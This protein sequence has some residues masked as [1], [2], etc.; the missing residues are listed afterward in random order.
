M[1]KKRV[2]D[3][4]KTALVLAGGG[5]TGV[6]YEMGAL[7]AIDDLLIDLKATFKIVLLPRG[8]EQKAYYMQDRFA[9]IIVP[10]KSISLADVMENCDLFIGAGGTMTREAAVLGIPTISIYQDKLLDVDNYLIQNQAMI[11]EKDLTAERVIRF[12]H[13]VQRRPSNESLLQKGRQAYELIKQ[14][15]LNGNNP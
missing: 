2:S 9:P 3:Q 4:G 14:V 13:E 12:V 15:L 10:E 1:M 8:E 5:L 6:V 7:R 11:H